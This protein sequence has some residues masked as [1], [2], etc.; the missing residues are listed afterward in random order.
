MNSLVRDHYGLFE[1]YQSLR[2]QL[3]ALL[4][5]ADLAFQPGGTNASLGALCREIGEVEQAYLQSFQTFQLDFSYRNETPGLT[6]S[7]AKLAAWLAGLDDELKKAVSALSEADIH[8]R[9][10]ERGGRFNVTPHHQLLIYQE[11]LL[12]FYGKVS[13]YLKLLGKSLP[14]QWQDWIG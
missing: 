5:D 8:N 11:A 2:D 14:E 6:G 10:I 3:L 4:T 12:I 13:V 9:K 1:L 7:V